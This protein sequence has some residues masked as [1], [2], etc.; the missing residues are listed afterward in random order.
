[1]F[2]ILS[3]KNITKGRKS[4]GICAYAHNSIVSGI[5]QVPTNGSKTILL[6]PNKNFFLLDRPIV[7]SFCYCDPQGITVQFLQHYKQNSFCK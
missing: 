4:G 5:K 1:M 3:G 6:K 2:P 7:V